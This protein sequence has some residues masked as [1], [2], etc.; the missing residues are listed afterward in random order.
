MQTSHP[1]ATY[2]GFVFLYVAHGDT[3][4]RG[5]FFMFK[6]PFS[7]R[8]WKLAAQELK[9]LR[10]LAIAALFVGLRIVV[11]T[12][13]IPLGDNLRIY[14][15]FFVP[16]LG[17]L[18]YGPFVGMLSGFASDILGYFVHPSGGFF[19]GY[20]VTAILSGLVY[21]LFFYRARITV[22]RIF[23]CKFCIN[24]F[25]NVGL[26]SLWSAILYGKGFYYYMAKSIVK[27]TLLLPLEVLLLVLFFQM[28]LPV[29][30]SRGLIPKQDTKR[31]PFV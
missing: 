29:I 6:T 13:F 4:F 2:W 21:A 3:I 23:F 17:S 15:S 26:G 27:N 22:V 19:P 31:I 9:I 10:V 25:I 1:A 5:G 7:V 20:T 18:I 16:A 14:F 11:S 24:L 30:G 28:L 12:F 8:Y